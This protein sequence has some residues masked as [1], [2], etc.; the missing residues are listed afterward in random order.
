LIV[1]VPGFLQ[2][3][4]VLVCAAIAVFAARVGI[5]GPEDVNLTTAVTTIVILLAITV[6]V[7]VLWT[8]GYISKRITAAP[9]VHWI[10]TALIIVEYAGVA[11][12]VLWY[13]PCEGDV[14]C[15]RPR[16]LSVDG[17]EQYM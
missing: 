12:L 11:A 16:L 4:A 14:F 17:E 13:D 9:L 3:S 6:V 5:K 7:R 2:Q 1:Q 10:I 8:R 15:V